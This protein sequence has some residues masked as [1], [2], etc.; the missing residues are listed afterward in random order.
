MDG[1]NQYQPFQKHTKSAIHRVHVFKAIRLRHTVDM[2]PHSKLLANEGFVCDQGLQTRS[3]CVTHTG[4][5][6]PIMAHCSLELLGSRDPSAS[7]SQ[8]ARTTWHMPPP[9]Y[10]LKFSAEVGSHF[11]AQTSPKLLG[12]NDPPSLASQTESH[13]VTRLECSGTILAHCNLC[14]LGSSNSPASASR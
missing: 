6:W 9:G 1:N 2:A 7:A 5:P 10:F 8:V 4:V 12:S 14:L 3:F 11:I 13:S